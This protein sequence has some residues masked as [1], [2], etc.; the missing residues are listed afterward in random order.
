MLPNK[1]VAIIYLL[2]SDEPKKYLLDALLKISAQ[3]YPKENLE[4]I[5][6]YNFH[7]PG[8]ES[9]ISFIEKEVEKQKNVLPHTTILNQEKNLG[10]TG[11]NNIGMNWALQNGFD[12]VFLHNADGFLHPETIAK[13]AEAMEKDRSIGQIQPLIMLHPENNLINSAG[14]SLHYLGMGYCRFERRQVSEFNFKEIESVSYVSGAATMLRADLLK[15]YGLLRENFFL[16]HEDT[17][18]S[19][20]LKMLGYKT[21]MAGKALFYHQY[22]FSRSITKLFWMERNR[23]AI[24]LIFY[25]A[26]TLILLL[27]LEIIYNCGLVLAA[28]RGKWLGE[29]LKVYKYWLNPKNWKEWLKLRRETQAFRV[30]ND[31]ELMKSFVLTVDSGEKFVGRPMHRL[32]NSIFTIYGNLV[33]ILIKW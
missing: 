28:L 6:V 8:E 15:K 3:T 25:K 27:P 21:A 1:K 23:H 4:L 5:I 7:K 10:F 11:G 24:K 12:Y 17:E 16:Y 22:D 18:M 20:R 26:P 13:L 30:I 2:W 31:A 32:A 29:L 33:K 9:E 14:N 19:L